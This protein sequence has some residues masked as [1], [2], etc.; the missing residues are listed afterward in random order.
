MRAFV[1][2][3][4]CDE[5]RSLAARLQGELGRAEA[6]VRWTPEA[7]MHLTLKF[8]GEIDDAQEAR[9]AAAL[10]AEV[11]RRPPMTLE[12]SGLGSFPPKGPPRVIWAGVRGDVGRLAEL[13]ALVERAAE[14]AGVPREDRPYTPHLTL[15]RVRSA[16][17]LRRLEA[18]LGRL[19]DADLGRQEAD[20]VVLYASTMAPSGAVH[21]PRSAVRCSGRLPAP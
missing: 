7:Q 6:D 1:A 16:R 19:G 17:N 18:A 14:E 3:P 12:F 10:A 2:L 5:V 20:E 4:L 8:L 13:A 15:G 21:E 9:I 11:P